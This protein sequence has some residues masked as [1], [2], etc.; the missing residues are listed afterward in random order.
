MSTL[1][2]RSHL[3]AKLFDKVTK[4]SSRFIHL[5]SPAASGNTTLLQFFQRFYCERGITCIYVTMLLEN[6]KG[7]LRE[8]ILTVAN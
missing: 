5:G 4:S 8:S 1:L 3:V 6:F 2:P 7:E